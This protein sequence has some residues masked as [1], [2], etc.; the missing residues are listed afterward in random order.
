AAVRHRADATGKSFLPADEQEILKL[1]FPFDHHLRI[2]PARAQHLNIGD[3][4]FFVEHYGFRKRDAYSW[5]R[6]DDDWLAA[7][8]PLA[9]Q[10]DKATNN[11]SLALAIELSEGGKVLLFPGDAQIGNW[12][13]WERCSWLESDGSKERKVTAADLLARTWL[14]K[15]GHHASHNATLRA[16]G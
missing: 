13:S 14:Y 12:L 2:S 16:K 9:L 3:K 7:A 11:T 5:R 1:S 6:I 8:G 10:L 15:V 4:K